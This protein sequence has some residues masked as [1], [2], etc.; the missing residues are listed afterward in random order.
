MEL[1]RED[2]CLDAPMKLLADRIEDAMSR[3]VYGKM[4][5]GTVFFSRQSGLCVTGRNAERMFGDGLFR[6][7]GT[8]ST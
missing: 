6:R 8:G 1:M 3:R 2:G 4:Q 5:T 7:S